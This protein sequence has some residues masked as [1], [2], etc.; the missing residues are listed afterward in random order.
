MPIHAKNV[1]STTEKITKQF[2]NSF[3]DERTRFLSFIHDH[4]PLST[5]ETIESYAQLLFNRL[6]FLYF[7]QRKGFL[8]GERDY[9]SARLALSQRLLGKD[10]FYRS[11]LLRFFAEGLHTSERSDEL[12]TLFGKLP[13]LD[14]RLFT[15]R[16]WE[17]QGEL[18]FCIPD[19]AFE[20]LFRFFDGYEW[21]LTESPHLHSHELNPAILGAIFEQF[22]NQR[23][24]GAYYTQRDI[25]TYIVMN[26]VIPALF[27][28]LEQSC[29]VL[30]L[31]ASPFWRCLQVQP[32]RYLASVLHTPTALADE[33]IEEG[34]QRRAH[35]D[36]LVKKLQAGV[37]TSIDQ[38]VTYNLDL[39]QLALD[40]ILHI[41]NPLHLMAFYR[42][43][44]KLTILD[45]ACGSGAFLVAALH[46][47][48]PLYRT[49]INRLQEAFTTHELAGADQP[50]PGSDYEIH[51]WILTHNLYGIDIMPDAIELCQFHLYLHLLACVQS[52]NDLTALPSLDSQ[53]QVG[54]VLQTLTPSLPLPLWYRSFLPLLDDGGFQA[55]IGNPPYVEYT[56]QNFP[57]TLQDFS[58]LACSNLYPCMIERGYRLFAPNGRHGMIVPLAAF[59]TRNMQPFLEGFKQWFPTSWVSF[60]HFRPAML[61]SGQ[62]VASIP[63]AIF[64]AKTQGETQRFST[65]LH[66]W[67]HE[68]RHLLFA[69]LRYCPVTAPTDPANQHYY[70][71]ISHALENTLLQKVFQHVCVKHYL[72]AV[73][74]ENRMFYRTAGG[75]YWKVFL[76]FPWPYSTT[77]NKVCSFQEAYDRDI[78][79]A[80]FNSSLFWWYYT[81][82][83]DTFNLKDYMLFG[84]HFTYPEAG[85]IRQR[86]KDLCSLLMKDFARHAQ[87][88]TRG[89][90]GSYTIYA[91]KSK[92]IIDAIDKTLGQYYGFS[93]AEQAFILRYDLKYRLGGYDL[94]S[95]N[96]E[97]TL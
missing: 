6:M 7:L 78:F 91:R 50:L 42:C 28:Q 56:G 32:E 1:H 23:H 15:L 34:F 4:A 48:A 22:V 58:T 45:P 53:L 65:Q 70:P 63:T 36:E 67:S 83:F 59:A 57:Y 13:S 33:S 35:Y 49:C 75:L 39:C 71:K 17:L 74:N 55:V 16:S 80:L 62:K 81:V 68:H 95:F 3:K 61:F 19:Q 40:G 12:L 11:F 60:Y 43:L 88:R 9:L 87:H 46:L 47:L 5:S 2:Y 20:H 44:Q 97:I 51:V 84:F 37:I 64:L 73:A 10:A 76:N 93:E 69:R 24:M 89:S 14:C 52:T 26:T 38:C 29:P 41:S 86:L 8:N 25:T 92:P 96:D 30:L 27:D 72:S 18:R 82:T 90:T 94:P 77:S 66:K 85:P 21:R 31:P 54:N 79:V